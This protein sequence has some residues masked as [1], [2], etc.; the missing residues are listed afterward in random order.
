MESVRI[1]D[2][3]IRF[4]ILQIGVGSSKKEVMLAYGLKETLSNEEENEYAVQMVFI[5]HHSILMK[6]TEYIKLHVEQEYSSF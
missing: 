5:Q 6:M 2:P 3:G 4:G 1:T